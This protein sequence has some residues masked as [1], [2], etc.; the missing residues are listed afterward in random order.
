MLLFL[1]ILTF[2][3]F[4][5]LS[6]ISV[7]SHDAVY[8]YDSYFW[9]LEEEGRWL[10]Y[11]SFQA[12]KH[13]P[14][15]ISIFLS[16]LCLYVFM[17]KT[18]ISIT[19]NKL[20]STFLA[21]SALQ[22]P[23]VYALVTW[24]VTPLPSY[25]LLCFAAYAYR[26]YPCI[27]FIIFGILF[28]GAFNNFYNLLPLLFI[29][30]IINNKSIRYTI[31]IVLLWIIGFIIGHLV[32]QG[33]TYILTGHLI[34][35]AEWRAPH[36]VINIESLI[37]NTQRVISYLYDHIHLLN[38]S[39]I[40]IL[41][42]LLIVSIKKYQWT[43]LHIFIIISS[44][45]LSTYIQAIPF[46]L[47]V[48]ARTPFSLYIALIS[49]LIICYSQ[50]KKFNIL[51]TIIAVFFAYTAYANNMENIKYYR[52][53]TD[54]Y[55]YHLKKSGINLSKYKNI[56]FTSTNEEVT[57]FTNGIIK[58]NKLHTNYLET[59]NTLRWAPV[60]KELKA[61]NV[62][63]DTQHDVSKLHFIPYG[64]YMIAEDKDDLI[65]K[66]NIIASTEKK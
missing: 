25:L 64:I 40:Y 8:Y 32:A 24:P 21:L 37:A 49:I 43:F 54:T 55:K 62:V 17:Y 23:S 65:V 14:A 16:F 1:S 63:L 34:Q 31:K 9:K 60:A 66:L 51:I 33:I 19:N 39:I 58:A 56:V 6:K 52:H 15:H 13:T 22:I 53:I 45:L 47:F 50:N 42:C 27:F 38:D 44:V 29:G 46:G 57:Q 4:F 35:I 26:R 18:S 2:N 48:S 20:F 7:W 59:F 3:T 30:K 36:P 10:N 11:I 28:N 12:L 41:I 61:N 5:E